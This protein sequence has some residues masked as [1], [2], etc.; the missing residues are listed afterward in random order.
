MLDEAAD[1]R[2]VLAASSQLTASPPPDFAAVCDLLRGL[3][4]CASVSFND[5]SLASGDFRY[6]ITP[7]EDQPLARRLKPAY[8]RHASQHPLIAYA[9]EHPSAG[10]LRFCDVPAGGRIT[11][12]ALFREFYEPF[13][14]RYQL[15][16][17]LPAP[18]DVIIGYALNRPA[19]QGEFSDREVSLV[20]ALAGQL[21][22]HHRVVNDQEIVHVLSA[23]SDRAGW[24]VITVRS[25]GVV[26]GSSSSSL[27]PG[28][29]TGH[30][31]PPGVAAL[32]PAAGDASLEARSHDVALGT[33][34]W[35]CIVTPVLLGPTVVMMRSLGGE[36]ARATPLIDAG[37]TPR[38]AAIALSLARTGASN[39]T[40]ARSLSISEGTVK[41][42]LEAIFR[43][44]GVESR[45]AAAV[46]VTALVGQAAPGEGAPP[47]D[48][49]PGTGA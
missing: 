26:E 9:Q 10:A 19:E 15:V 30:M 49:L 37:L 16:I 13:G 44:L 39:A 36:D 12:T 14:V 17:Q 28:L 47:P 21:A 32:L 18:P 27:S 25:D 40:L 45:A 3:V 2:A 5:M 6:V 7:V 11:D 8:D 35:R 1:L 20:N 41:K 31:V 43:V 22:M 23:Q 48:A 24:S 33:E 46:A 38:Q 4:P 29:R 34:L 42:H